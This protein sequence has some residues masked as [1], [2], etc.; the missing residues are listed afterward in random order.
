MPNGEHFV[1]QAAKFSVLTKWYA[2]HYLHVTL[3]A[4]KIHLCIDQWYYIS[5]YRLSISKGEK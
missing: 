3:P 1:L 5:F 2:G 4:A